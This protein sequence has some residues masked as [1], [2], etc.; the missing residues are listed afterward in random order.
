MS[1]NGYS[2]TTMEDIAVYLGVSKGALYLY[3]KRKV[4]T[5]G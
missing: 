1:E 5:P 4:S 3:F 2:Q